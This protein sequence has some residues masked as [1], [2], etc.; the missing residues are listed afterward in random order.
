FNFDKNISPKQIGQ[1]WLNYCLENQTVLAW[2]GKGILTEESAYMNLK[3][4][5]HAPESGSIA[6]NGKVIAEQI[7][8]QIFIDG[9]GMVSPGDPEQAVDLAKR[10]GSVSHDGES[11][12]GAQVVAAMEAYAFIEKDIKKIIEDSKKFVPNDSTIYKLISD[13]QDWSSGNLDWEQAR[14]K[15][16]DKYGYSKFPGNCH[17]VPNHALIILSLL[18]GDD[19]FQKTL[20]I[21]NTAGWDTDCNSGNVGCILGIKNGLEGI[22]QGPDYITPVNDIIYLPT[23]YGSE[24]MTDALLESQNIIN[25]TRKMNG[26][27]SKVIKNNARYNFEM[28]TST[29]GWMVDK[30]NDNNLNTSLSNVDYKSDNGTRALQVSFNDLSFGLASE[31]FVDSFFPEWFT[32]LEGYQVQRYFHYDYVACP[33]VYSGQK[34][35]TEI[36]SQSEKDLRINLFI[37]YWGEED[38]LIK[39]SSDDFNLRSKE[40]NTIEWV[41]PDTFANP[42]GQ[43]GISINSDDNV[44]GK[45]LINYLN[46][47]GTPKMTFRRPDHIDEYKRGIFYKEEVY[48]QLWKR[49]WVNDVDKW[50]YRHN[51]SFKVVRGIGR[52]HIMTGSETWKDYTISA[53]ISIPLASAAGLIVRSQGLK[54]YYSLELTSENKLKINKME[55]ELKTL[56]EIDFSLEYFK[57]Y[58]LKFKVDGNKLQG[59]VDNQLLIE[60]ED[61][62][63]PFEEGMMGF[64]TENGAIQ[65]NSISIE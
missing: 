46:I 15:I 51:E 28:E 50:Q 49:A 27:E 30:S 14:S 59:Y 45:I 18:F 54:R 65:S 52:G 41:V 19:D 64:L 62:S 5:I 16:E 21:V 56:N 55:Y 32:K 20:M 44:S 43:I 22:K 38:K 42:I 17:I 2:A 4:G 1:T 11:V 24:T 63:N 36:I 12:Y 13:I 39:L 23:A 53:K 57:D 6:K 40:N 60:A 26:L 25:I 61:S 47:S 35:K 31:I 29:Q 10:A 9:W 37:K 3:Q 58:D 33:I 48:G 34:I 8:A 7:G